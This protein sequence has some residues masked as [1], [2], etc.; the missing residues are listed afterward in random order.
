MRAI[1]TLL[2]WRKK[3]DRKRQTKSLNDF[4]SSSS[5]V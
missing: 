5:I 1:S 3:A 2:G 4:G